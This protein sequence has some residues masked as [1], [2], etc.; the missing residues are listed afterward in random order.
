MGD[1]SL[2]KRIAYE[3]PIFE[4][5]LEPNGAL[6][7]DPACHAC[8]YYGMLAAK[9]LDVIGTSNESQ[10]IL[11]KVGETPAEWMTA[12]LG[13]IARGV[14][15]MYALESPEVFLKYRKEAWLQA[16]MLGVNIPE[17]VFRVGPGTVIA[18]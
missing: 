5:Y 12:N 6:T 3:Y 7:L 9:A 17:Y 11:Y 10:M 13:N 8:F 18:H 1:E 15:Q 16:S 2:Q 14:A 4:N